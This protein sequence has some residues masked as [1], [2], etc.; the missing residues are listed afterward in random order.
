M[1]DTT[2]KGELPVH[3]RLWGTPN[4][5]AVSLPATEGAGSESHSVPLSALPDDTFHAMIE[6]WV[7]EMYEKAGKRRPSEPPRGR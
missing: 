1:T 6:E 3:Y 2:M 4:Y 7:R 5:V